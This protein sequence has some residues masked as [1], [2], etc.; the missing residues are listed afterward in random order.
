VISG[1]V[2]PEGSVNTPN[3]NNSAGKQRPGMYDNQN[4]A[5]I[6]AFRFC[7]HSLVSAPSFVEN[8][9]MYGLC[10]I[11]KVFVFAFGTWFLGFGLRPVGT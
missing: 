2:C 11:Y 4:E 8:G 10:P 9:G 7:G 3:C 1:R 6:F 5:K